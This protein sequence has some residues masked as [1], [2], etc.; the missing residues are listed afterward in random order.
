MR[1]VSTGDQLVNAPHA[2]GVNFLMD[3][4]ETDES[5]YKQPTHLLRE[6]AQ[7]DEARLRLSLI[8]LFLEHP[9][10]ASYVCAVAEKLN[11]LARLTLQCYYSV[12][13]WLAKKHQSG[14]QLCQTSSLK[15]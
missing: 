2:L 15:T 3:S 4:K 6:L 1:Q 13:I 9:E 7:S 14:M 11:P 5:L 8:P 10:H 12:A